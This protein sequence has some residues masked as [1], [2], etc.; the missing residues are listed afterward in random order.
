MLQQTTN[1]FSQNTGPTCHITFFLF[2][3]D[4]FLSP[5]PARSRP[6]PRPTAL[7]SRPR[8]RPARSMTPAP[9]ARSP[10][11]PTPGAANEALRSALRVCDVEEAEVGGVPARSLA[12]SNPQH[13]TAWPGDA[14]RSWRW[15]HHAQRRSGSYRWDPSIG[16]RCTFRLIW[17]EMLTDIKKLW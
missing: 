2:S 5:L 3:L 9:P 13:T 8:P 14:R 12:S 4:I 10:A 1:N 11:A 16:G 17:G 15:T 6:L 7:W